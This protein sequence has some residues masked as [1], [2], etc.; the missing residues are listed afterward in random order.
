[1]AKDV[2]EDN[3]L[4]LEKLEALR[5]S[6]IHMIIHDLRTPLTSVISGMETLSYLG[7]LTLM[8]QETLSIATSGGHW[9]Y[10]VGYD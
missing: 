6:L 9:P 8:Q 10:A 1:M 4:Q 2:A 5:D 3:F 7:E